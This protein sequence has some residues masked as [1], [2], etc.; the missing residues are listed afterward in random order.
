MR[1]I[2]VFRKYNLLKS[3]LKNFKSVVIAFSGGLDSSFLLKATVDV[4]GRRVIAVTAVSADFPTGALA[5]AKTI[6][7]RIAVSHKVVRTGEFTNKKFLNNTPRRCY[8][9]KKELFCL[10]DEFARRRGYSAVFDGTIADDARDIRPG[11]RANKEYGVISPLQDA[12]LFKQVIRFLAKYF[13][14]SFWDKPKGTCLSSRI[15]TGEKITLKRIKRIDKAQVLLRNFLGKNILFRLRDHKDIARLEFARE[16]IS[17]IVAAGN[18]PRAIVRLKKLG[19]K[20]ITVDLE[21]YIPAG[22]RARHLA[23]QAIKT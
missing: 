20:Y 16:D 15:P 22:I 10:L 6:A 19:Y 11:L 9:C 14:L 18:W 1:K 5:E 17:S 8:W 23:R 13:G 4:L 12:G 2:D 3:R 7:R 21:G